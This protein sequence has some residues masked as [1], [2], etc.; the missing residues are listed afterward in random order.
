MN[1]CHNTKLE[2]DRLHQIGNQGENRRHQ[3]FFLDTNCKKNRILIVIKPLASSYACILNA[4]I[5]LMRVCTYSPTLQPHSQDICG[6]HLL[7]IRYVPDAKLQI[8]YSDR[9]FPRCLHA[10]VWLIAQMT[11]SNSFQLTTPPLHSAQ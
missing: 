5:V 11:I 6:A 4:K 10:N 7:R 1:S 3:P 8:V 2:L 9:D